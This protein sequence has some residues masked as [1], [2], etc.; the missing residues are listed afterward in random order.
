MSFRVKY[1][2]LLMIV[3][4]VWGLVLAAGGGWILCHPRTAPAHS[5][6]VSSS[7]IV[8]AEKAKLA[9]FRAKHNLAVNHWIRE[10]DL[11]WASPLSQGAARTDFLNRY[12]ACPIQAG[13]PVIASETRVFPQIE[14]G[15]DYVAYRLGILDPRVTQTLNAGARVDIW[16]ENHRVAQNILALA[17]ICTSSAPPK[18]CS[19]ILDIPADQFFLLRSS[20]PESLLI[21]PR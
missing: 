19:A 17:V 7:C 11:D 10:E 16:D 4:V 2:L 20:K 13:E 15:S 6:A 9:S 21:I 3:V 12:S 14:P 5:V 1:A 8:A 18:D